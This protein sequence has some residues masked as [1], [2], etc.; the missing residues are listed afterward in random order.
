MDIRVLY[1]AEI[2]GKAGIQ[3]VKQLLPEIKERFSIDFVIGNINGATNG[4]GI[5]KNHAGY[6]HKLG[7]S[8]LTGGDKIYY[9]KDLVDDFLKCTTYCALQIFRT[10]A[11][12]GAGKHAQ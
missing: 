3:C 7:I 5:G 6:L 12:D 1:I 8:V 2:V 10:K 4:T 11:P 9:K